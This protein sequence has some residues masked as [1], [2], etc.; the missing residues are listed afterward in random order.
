MATPLRNR[1]A[2][3][4]LDDMSNRTRTYLLVE[5]RLGRPLARHV[6]KLR[7]TE[8]RAATSWDQIAHQL[9]TDTGINV[10]SETLRLWFFD[11]EQKRKARAEARIAGAAA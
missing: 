11:D 6:M 10:T 7:G 5:E 9:A 4:N 2:Y 8:L 1:F 3:V